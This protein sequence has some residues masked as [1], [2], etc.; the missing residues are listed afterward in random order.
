MMRKMSQ[1]SLKL[2]LMM[3]TLGEV[4]LFLTQT[5]SNITAAICI[6]FKPTVSLSGWETLVVDVRGIESGDPF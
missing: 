1:R 2:P 6:Q 3:D 5:H 4:P